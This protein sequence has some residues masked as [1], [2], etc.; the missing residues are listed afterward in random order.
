MFVCA[1]LR[2][3]AFELEAEE[4]KIKINKRERRARVAAFGP[5][6]EFYFRARIRS[7]RLI[8]NRVYINSPF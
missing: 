5:A 3:A 6:H 4:N 7:E 8:Y 1:G 2:S